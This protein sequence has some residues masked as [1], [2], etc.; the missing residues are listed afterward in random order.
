MTVAELKQLSMMYSTKL[1]ASQGLN[2]VSLRAEVVKRC[3]HV[4]RMQEECHNQCGELRKLV[5]IW[6]LEQGGAGSNDTRNGGRATPRTAT[7]SSSSVGSSSKRELIENYFSHMVESIE[8]AYEACTR[9]ISN[10][11]TANEKRFHN[12]NT[13]RLQSDEERASKYQYYKGTADRSAP[14]RSPRTASPPKQESAGR[15]EPQRE[16]NRSTSRA[17]EGTSPKRLKSEPWSTTPSPPT[18]RSKQSKA[19]L[20]EKSE[21]DRH[22][23]PF[24]TSPSPGRQLASGGESVSKNGASPNSDGEGSPLTKEAT[25]NSILPVEVSAITDGGAERERESQ[26][27]REAEEAEEARLQQEREQK[28]LEERQ[29]LQ[30]E[31]KLRELEM[32]LGSLEADE[33]SKRTTHGDAELAER[34]ALTTAES[35]GREEITQRLARAPSPS[36]SPDRVE[37]SASCCSSGPKPTKGGPAAAPHAAGPKSVGGATPFQPP[38]QPTGT[39]RPVPLMSAQAVTRDQVY[40]GANPSQ[41]APPGPTGTNGSVPA[42]VAGS[43]QLGHPPSNSSQPQPVLQAQQRPLMQQPPPSLATQQPP[44]TQVLVGAPMRGGVPNQA[45]VPP[46]AT[47]G[48][49][50]QPLSA[51]QPQRQP[52]VY[53]GLSPPV[54]EATSLNPRTGQ[55]NYSAPRLQ[56]QPQPK[57]T[58]TVGGG[59]PLPPQ[60]QQMPIG[61]MQGQAGYAVRPNPNGGVALQPQRHTP[62]PQDVTARGPMMAQGGPPNYPVPQVNGEAAARSRTPTDLGGAP[63][64]V[65]RPVVGGSNPST[66]ANNVPA[67]SA[68][69]AAPPPA[70]SGPASGVTAPT[71]TSPS[72]TPR[73]DTPTASGANSNTAPA[74]SSRLTAI[75]RRI[76]VDS[77][78]DSDDDKDD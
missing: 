34:S 45:S 25:E 31:Q 54:P 68:N 2:A 63:Q 77:N 39:P 13:H 27:K 71:S 3:L 66:A 37:T 30:R 12:C 72:A 52:Q 70:A 60:Q 10:L 69:A 35:K 42:P 41:R 58:G 43:K 11:L 20:K 32:Q 7:G 36:P 57:P 49:A 8:D 76:A 9:L 5:E 38:V 23:D 55:P 75:L 19:P 61:P 15:A 48:P 18:N 21:R 6:L 53:A 40:G 73:T 17:S 47:A 67:A 24:A 65:P 64:P 59:G 46:N 16:S 56:P 33:A 74:R 44:P 51:A 4:S 22:A 50:P 78:S 14:K 29:R 26:L 28:E 1:G 62:P